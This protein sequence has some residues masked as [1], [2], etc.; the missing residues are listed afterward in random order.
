[1]SRM[2]RTNQEHIRARFAQKT[3]VDFAAS[4]G[5]Q[6]TPVRKLW[7]L[8]AAIVTCLALTA[9]TQPLFS[10]LDGDELSLSGSYEGNGV[11][12]VRVENRSDKWLRFQEQ[13]KL[14]R[15]VTSEEVTRLPG[16]PV[17]HNTDF[18]P[19]SQGVMTIDLSEAYDV[20]SLEQNGKEWYYLLLT[21]NQ[22]LFGQD[23]MC[24]LNFSETNV[25]PEP[26]EEAK[27]ISI[28]P[29]EPTLMNNIH[30]DL[31]FYFEDIYNGELMAFNEANFRYQQKVD[32]LLTRFDGTIVPALAPVLMVGGPSEFLDPEP[33]LK[34]TPD[35]V[36]FDAS[37]P[38]EQQYL[39]TQSSWR[40]TD[41]FGRMVATV[42]EKAWVQNVILP[43][44]Q[45]Q[46]DGGTA[47]P[48]VFLFVYDASEVLPDHY[49][50]IYGQILSFAEMETYKV[51]EDEHYIIYDA[52]DLIYSDVDTY[53]DGFI[54]SGQDV[55][56]DEQI[57]QRVRRVYDYYRNQNNL[58]QLYDYLSFP[59]P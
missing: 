1:M 32:E 28:N 47:L 25:A 23:W 2:T 17:F 40:F 54:S 53:L 20:E 27:T 38:Q 5:K 21:N 24:S 8:A 26:E 3:G 14:M 44:N 9:F 30:E 42:N 37:I 58:R 34:K 22:F 12:T 35:D 18:A 19:H 52:T 15:W 10:G 39:L 45:G 41:A 33:V 55:Y 56:C 57:R 31:R 4:S 43:Q 6:R 36:V 48:L 29:A 51:L 11:V 13:A 50:F 49:T 16:E 46:T 7:I 59:T